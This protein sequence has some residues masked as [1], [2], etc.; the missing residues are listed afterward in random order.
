MSGDP[1][2]RL[3]PA[4]RLAPAKLNLTLAVLG[5]R[6]DG[7]HDLHSVVVPLTLADRL[8]VTP[9]AGPADTL[10]V[11]GHDPG[12]PEQNL[13]LR[14]IQAA[15]RAVGRGAPTPP[16][17]VR[18][19]KRIPVAAGLGGGSSDAAAAIDAA[20]E[21]WAVAPDAVDRS[22]IATA[23][24]SDVPFFLAGGAAL[25]EGRGERVTPLPDLT[26]PPVGLL[27]VTPAVAVS[28]A[29]AFAAFDTQAGRG[30]GSTRLSSE[31]L[32]SEWRGGLSGEA[33]LV[34]AGV[35]AVAND[36]AAAANVLEPAL[37]P[38]RRALARL[39]SRPIGQSGSGP[40]LWAL[41]PSPVAAEAA[42]NEVRE[43]IEAGGLPSIGERPPTIVGTTILATAATA[44]RSS[45]NE[46][47]PA[48]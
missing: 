36:L 34:R 43:A 7:F 13:A 5:R 11:E 38:F 47:A 44:P 24:G 10:R 39:L 12:P 27:L 31:H 20:L 40:T 41:Y 22:A 32:A 2:G 6:K 42:A 30:S 45:D 18:L 23:I 8:S 16:L 33:L 9:S 25:L 15:R 35:L 19:E 28:T 48:R 29:E 17:A 4:I 14:A 21:A 1:F 3:T 37:V 26:A 46:E